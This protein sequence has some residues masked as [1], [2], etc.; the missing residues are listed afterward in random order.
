MDTAVEWF[1]MEIV[2]KSGTSATRLGSLRIYDTTN[3]FACGFGSFWSRR[4]ERSL[5]ND[6]QWTHPYKI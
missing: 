2:S 6:L 5:E 3:R 4:M 1:E